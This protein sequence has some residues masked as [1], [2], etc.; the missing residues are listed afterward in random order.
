MPIW[1]NFLPM[2]MLKRLES[3]SY[4]LD[5]HQVELPGHGNAGEAGTNDNGLEILRRLYLST[6]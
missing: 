6:R 4:L 5:V 1:L 2:T 3:M